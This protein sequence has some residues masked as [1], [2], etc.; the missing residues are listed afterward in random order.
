MRSSTLLNRVRCLLLLSFTS[1]VRNNVE[2]ISENWRLTWDQRMNPKRW[3]RTKPM[4]WIEGRA[5]SGSFHFHFHDVSLAGR[6][7]AQQHALEPREVLA[8]IVVQVDQI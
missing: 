8:I 4:K 1:F 3:R 7:H 5:K 2:G 6:C